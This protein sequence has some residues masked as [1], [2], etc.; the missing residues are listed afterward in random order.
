[1]HKK[2]PLRAHIAATYLREMRVV[3]GEIAR[4]LEPGGHLV[5]VAG[6]NRV[7]GERFPTAHYL[8]NLAEEF[9]LRRRLV[10]IDD[11]QSRG[12]MTKR[13]KNADVITQEWVYLLEKPV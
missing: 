12:L 4:V 8:A 13:N 9:G 2:N 6:N 11:I 1:V 5:L 3:F 7:C 10:L